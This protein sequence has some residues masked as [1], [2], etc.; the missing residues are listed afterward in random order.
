MDTAIADAPPRHA[1]SPLVLTDAEVSNPAARRRFTDRALDARGHEFPVGT[2]ARSQFLLA[3]IQNGHPTPRTQAA[4]LENLHV[5]LRHHP[6]REQPGRL[7]IGMGT[8]RSGSTTLSHILVS[9]GDACATHENPPM[10]YWTPEPDQIAFH[11]A[12]FALLRRHVALVADTAHWWINA[13]DIL[14]ETFPDL[15]FIGTWR[16]RDACVASFLRIKGEGPG[17]INHWL[18]P[19]CAGVAATNW[20]LAY[21]SYPVADP[22]Y[23]QLATGKR[24]LIARY[25]DDY[26]ARLLRLAAADPRRWLLLRTE[27]LNQPES[28]QRIFAHVGATGS[29]SAVRLNANTTADG[30]TAYRF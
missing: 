14:A 11:L 13:T 19:G 10:L 29:F 26:N 7:V 20:D 18:L 24:Q 27:T 3:I 12:R 15:R 8:G 30:E 23:S 16:D 22:G 1:P 25:V 17:S 5:L 21:P 9:C 4:Y 28:R 2:V 6:S